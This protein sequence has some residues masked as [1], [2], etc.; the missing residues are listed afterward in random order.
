MNFFSIGLHRIQKCVWFCFVNI[1]NFKVQLYTIWFVTCVHVFLC[2]VNVVIQRFVDQGFFC[3][4]TIFSN[5][6]RRL[7]YHVLMLF[8]N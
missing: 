6:N 2:C 4:R 7:Y 5:I 3:P 8:K 1:C